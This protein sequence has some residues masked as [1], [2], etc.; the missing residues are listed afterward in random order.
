MEDFGGWMP[1]GTGNWIVLQGPNGERQQIDADQ[2]Q[3]IDQMTRQG[4][5]PLNEQGV[6]YQVQEFQG[7]LMFGDPNRPGQWFPLNEVLGGQKTAAQQA[8]MPDFMAM[9]QGGGTAPAAATPTGP[10]S[11]GRFPLA[12]KGAQSSPS[13]F[14]MGTGPSAAQWNPNTADPFGLI[15]NGPNMPMS[16]PGINIPAPPVIPNRFDPQFINNFNDMTG[17]TAGNIAGAWNYTLPTATAAQLNLTGVPSPTAQQT[18]ISPELQRML[19]GEGYSPDILA[20]MRA[21]SIED[22]SGAGRT[23]MGQAR[24]AL[25]QAG[26]AESP[27]AAAISGDVA[28]RSGIAQ[29]SALRDIDIANALQGIQNMQFGIGQQTQIGMSNMAA[30]NQ[31][32][33]E[34]ANRLFAGMQQ[35][36]ANQQQTNMANFGA[37]ANQATNKAGA[38]SNFFANQGGNLQNAMLQNW[39]NANQ[40]NAANQMNWAGLQAQFARQRALANQGTLE[41]R[42]GTAARSLFGNNSP[43]NFNSGQPYQGWN[44]FAG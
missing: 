24:R 23:E 1:P 40:Q 8:A 10:F 14:N 3:Q 16:V 33:L 34:N 43:M 17:Q 27:A 44:P 9:L 30:A 5:V 35:S 26:L 2:H 37:A 42:W 12:V 39:Q 32:A 41:N 28:R 6:P 21:R 25:E 18:A 13:P 11:G 38:Q 7:G 29:N 31:M 19:A 4:W 22:V 36:L 20:G 15:D